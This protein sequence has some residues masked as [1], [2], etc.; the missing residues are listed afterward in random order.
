VAEE[1]KQ[2]HS[3]AAGWKVDPS[4]RFAGRYW[5]GTG[6]TEHVVDKDRV[7][8][9]DPLPS[10]P[11]QE[12]RRSGSGSAAAGAL[13][14]MPQWAKLAAVVAIVAAIALVVMLGGDDDAPPVASGGAPAET[15]APAAK[16]VHTVGETARTGDFDVTVFGFKDPETPGQFL[17]P[18]PGMHFVTVDVQ[19]TNRS[20]R[21]RSFSSLLGF[22]LLDGADRQFDA[23]FADIAPAAP[24]GDF[25]PGQALRGLALFEVPDGTTGL[26]FRA[27]A[28]LDDPGVLFALR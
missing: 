15:A 8:S 21:Q 4:G 22:R 12:A 16:A 20:S 10:L 17:Q 2:K 9:I 3:R 11:G 27:H 1:V 14:R 19:L 6:W 18:A 23:T 5:N 7:T 25:P 28:T 13:G 26:S 24:D